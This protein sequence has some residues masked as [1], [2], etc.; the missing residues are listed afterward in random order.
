[1]TRAFG[2]RWLPA[3]AILLAFETIIAPA[4]TQVLP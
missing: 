1:M 2:L 4:M 3:I